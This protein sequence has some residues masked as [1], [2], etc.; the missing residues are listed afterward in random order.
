MKG[1]IWGDAKLNKLVERFTTKSDVGTERGADYHLL[2]YAI[3]FEKA[4]IEFLYRL[5]KLDEKEFLAVSKNLDEALDDPDLSNYEDLHSYIEDVVKTSLGRSIYICRSR[6]DVITAIERLYLRDA[7]KT[8]VKELYNLFE[9]LLKALD[10][11]GDIPAPAHTHY[12]LADVIPLKAYFLSYLEELYRIISFIPHIRK[13]IYTSPIGS[14]AIGGCPLNIDFTWLNRYLGFEDRHVTSIDGVNSRKTHNLHILILY[15][16]LTGLVARI[17]RDMIR[18]STQY[19]ILELPREYTTGSS[20]LIH[21]INPDILELMIGLHRHLVSTLATIYQHYAEE[22]GYQRFLQLDKY[23]VIK[24]TEDVI[25]SIKIL[26]G[27]IENIYIHETFKGIEDLKLTWLAAEIAWRYD[28][29]YREIYKLIK[30]ALSMEE[31]IESTIKRISREYNINQKE[32]E[33]LS[34]EIFSRRYNNS[35]MDNPSTLIERFEDMFKKLLDQ[36]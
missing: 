30:D 36:G 10:R 25:A 9:S 15:S 12:V 17:S 21:K 14:G 4:Y 13:I 32:L 8:L 33:K 27:L 7:L 28:L 3:R 20:Q 16:Q 22:S 31:P 1:Y 6:N 23:N 5:G 34:K 35:I 18:L 24:Y 11:A 19:K 2:P 29:D 26:S